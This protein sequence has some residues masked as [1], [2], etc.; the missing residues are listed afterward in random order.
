MEAD[1]LWFRSKWSIEML[2]YQ[3]HYGK[4]WLESKQIHGQFCQQ[5]ANKTDWKVSIGP[6][7]S[8]WYMI[9]FFRSAR[10]AIVFA[11]YL[12]I[13]SVLFPM[14]ASLIN[15]RKLPIILKRLSYDTNYRLNW[16]INELDLLHLPSFH[17]FRI[18]FSLDYTTDLWNNLI[19]L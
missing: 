8:L 13:Q 11:N 19:I 17:S 2:D 15:E 16:I 12:S 10:V 18:N 5:L 6:R 4:I 14:T 1:V 7:L 3:I 9:I